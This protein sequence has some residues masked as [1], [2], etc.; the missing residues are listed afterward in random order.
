MNSASNMI[1]KWY[2]N[3]ASPLPKA[4]E[5]ID[6]MPNARVGA[7]PVRE[8]S[9]SSST[10]CAAAVRSAGLIEKP[11]VPM[12]SAA[13][14]GSP[15]VAPAGEFIAKYRPWSMTD[16]AIR[17]LIATKDSISMAP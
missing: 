16:A 8:I 11:R 1:A 10:D 15:P 14:P 7:P 4:L 3:A 17:A 9:V 13:V 6:D 2:Q 12:N 5:K